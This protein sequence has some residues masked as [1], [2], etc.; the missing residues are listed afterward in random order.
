MVVLGQ[1]NQHILPAKTSYKHAFFSSCN[2]FLQLLEPVLFKAAS[3]SK[4]FCR[5][6]F[7]SKKDTDECTFFTNLKTVDNPGTRTPGYL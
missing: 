1:G 6:Y 3:V 5:V 2:H 4:E 7:L